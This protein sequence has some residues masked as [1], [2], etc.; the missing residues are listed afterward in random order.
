MDWNALFGQDYFISLTNEERR[1]LALDPIRDDWDVTQ[2]YN[3]TN[4]KYTRTTVF[5]EK[6]DIKKIVY[7]ENRLPVGQTNPSY[8]AITEHDTIIKTENREKLIPLTPRGK[9]KPVTA[10][11][12]MSFTPFGCS[13]HFSISCRSLNSDAEKDPSVHMAIYN[14]RNDCSVPIG[15]T[16][17]VASIRGDQD[18][19]SF[20]QYYI[21]TCPND[22]FDRIHHLRSAKHRTI[23]Y[24]TG[25]IFRIEIDRFHYGYGLITG[26]VLEIRKWPEL[27]RLHSLRSLMMV[28]IMV[29][30]YD[31]ITE[32]SD[33]KAEE[34]SE[35]QLSRVDICGDN[36]IIWG[37][38]TIIG[39]KELTEK[40]IEFNLVCTKVNKINS[41]YTTH[42]FDMLAAAGL[43]SGIDSYQLR[44]EWGTA[45]TFLPYNQLS[46]RLKEYLAEYR[47]PHSGVSIGIFPDI[48]K[49]RYSS[50][51]NLLNP[52]HDEMRAELFRCLGLSPDADFDAFAASYGG[53]TKKEILNKLSS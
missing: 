33:W 7:E 38:H 8:R 3:K 45:A 48:D 37:K 21:S 14:S 50:K 41:H 10:S 46:T 25:D 24:K 9:P 1:Y 31:L 13:F 35:Y 2:Y 23:P 34:L 52:D 42:T 51:M 5:W 18:F 27:P 40:D 6:D 22:Y 29:R 26:K 32:R 20:M 17:R 49:S 36:D 15:E 19:H 53:L 28:P 16:K 44:V 47:D 43:L 39:H 30:Y 12:I 4:I 11:N